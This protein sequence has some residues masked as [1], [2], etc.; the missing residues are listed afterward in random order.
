LSSRQAEIG[1]ELLA[2]AFAAILEESHHV[3][4]PTDGLAPIV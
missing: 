4:D 2:N 1:L 3:T